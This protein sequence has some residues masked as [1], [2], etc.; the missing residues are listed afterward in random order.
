[1]RESACMRVIS[2]SPACLLRGSIEGR[3]RPAISGVFQMR[4]STFLLSAA[5]GVL[6]SQ[7]AFAQIGE[8]TPPSQS[9]PSAVETVTVTAERLN[10]ARSGIQ[11]QTGASTYTITA[12]DIEAAPGGSN[13]L[14]NSVILQAPSVAQDSFGQI[15]VRGEHNA[16]QYR[17]NGVIIPE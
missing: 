11:T 9:G 14:L 3:A 5:V 13:N 17:L 12:Q 16:L 2:T 10:A 8:Q 1:M 6:A 7:S 15:H 4:R